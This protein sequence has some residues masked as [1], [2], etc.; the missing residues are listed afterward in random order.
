MSMSKRST[1]PGV[2]HRS[3]ARYWVVGALLLLG[4]LV[5]VSTIM[6]RTATSVAAME[7]RLRSA[8]DPRGDS[9]YTVRVASSHLS[10]LGGS[11]VA[12]GIE[13]TPDSE[14]FQARRLAGK[15][16]QTRYALRVGSFRVTGLDVW[17]LFRNRLKT[18]NAV[19][20]SMLIEIYLDRH[21]PMVI[22]SVRRLPH[23]F[24]ATIRKPF[25]LDTSVSRTAQ[26]VTPSGRSTGRGRARSASPRP[27]SASTIS[28]M[29]LSA[30]TRR[31]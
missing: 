30:L 21:A 23:E 17:G 1:S 11:Y 15:A 29:I 14:A 10:V 7:R 2:G 20:D 12:T 5:V 28:T 25:R 31:S 6:I 4:G 18:V 19:V 22:D 26:C 9:L 24:F 16:V 8:L 3:R 27:G 13:I